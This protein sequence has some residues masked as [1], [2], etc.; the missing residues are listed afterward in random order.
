[1]WEAEDGR[2]IEVARGP[3][4]NGHFVGGRS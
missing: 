4:L 1:V 3:A 2:R